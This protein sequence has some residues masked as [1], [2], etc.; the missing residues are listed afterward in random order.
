MYGK[1]SNENGWEIWPVLSIIPLHC[2]IILHFIK[3]MARYV[4][5]LRPL[6]VFNTYRS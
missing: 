5:D 3:E 4:F 1:D 2:H 6:Y